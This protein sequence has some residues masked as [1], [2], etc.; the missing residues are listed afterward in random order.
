MKILLCV[1]PPW[2]VRSPPLSLGYVSEYLVSHGWD[3]HVLDLNAR[4]YRSARNAHGHLWDMHHH[5]RWRH[6]GGVREILGALSPDLDLCLDEIEEAAPDLIGFSVVDPNQLFTKGVIAQLKKRLPGAPIVLGGP[7]CSTVSSRSIFDNSSTIDGFII[8]EGERAFLEL[9]T[10]ISRGNEPPADM[11]G[12]LWGAGTTQKAPA[13]Q[14]GSLDDLP[15]PKFERFDFSLYGGPGM[16]VIWSRGCVGHCSFCKERK[17][18]RGY[19]TKSPQT[20]FDEIRFLVEEYGYREFV[21]C[22]SAVN[23]NIQELEQVCDLLI[24]GSLNIRWS[25]QA[26][27]YRLTPTLLEKMRKAGCHTLVFGVES[28]SQ[29]VLRAMGKLFTIEDAERTLRDV[30]RI[31]IEC[32]VNLITGY[33]GETESCFQETLDFLVRNRGNIQRVDSASTLQLVEDVDLHDERAKHGLLL[34]EN[35]EYNNWYT[36]EGNT[37]EL[38]RGRLARLIGQIHSLGLSVGRN[39][40]EENS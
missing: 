17:L 30:A 15:F 8:G 26:I 28:G 20:R 24:A 34:T 14:V 9:V 11:D 6:P 32:W 38:R 21:V 10:A 40:L 1:C 16:A 7:A 2:G 3:V 13:R 27:P 22:D 31:G 33:P 23:G 35:E 25:A 29:K 5:A 4:L 36:A 18:W 12:V 19:R 37:I 39:F